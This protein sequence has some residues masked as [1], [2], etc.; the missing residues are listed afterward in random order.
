MFK[1]D[2]LLNAQEGMF[3]IS[4]RSLSSLEVAVGRQLF[5]A[6]QGGVKYLLE[7]WEKIL[8]WWLLLRLHDPLP[9]VASARG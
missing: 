3:Q 2:I 8:K 1:T 4:A 6:F 7:F 5:E 9:E